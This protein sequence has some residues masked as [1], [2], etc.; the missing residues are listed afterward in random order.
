MIEVS[1]TRRVGGTLAVAL[2]IAARDRDLWISLKPRVFSALRPLSGLFSA[3]YRLRS[4]EGGRLSGAFWLRLL[5]AER[6]FRRRIGQGAALTRYGVEIPRSEG[7]AML[8]CATAGT[9]VTDPHPGMKRRLQLAHLASEYLRALV[10]PG[11]SASGRRTTGSVSPSGEA[12]L[13]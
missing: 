9:N 13:L 6:R 7:W 8:S 11:T 1:H 4:P 10:T 2:K 12:R 3:D 5:A